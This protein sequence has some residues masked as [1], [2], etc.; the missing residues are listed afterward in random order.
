MSFVTKGCL[1]CLALIGALVLMIVLLLFVRFA[2]T[3]TGPT[4]QATGN[5]AAVT[6][7]IA[8]QNAYGQAETELQIQCQGSGTVRNETVTA[9]NAYYQ[10]YAGWTATVELS[11][12]C[13]GQR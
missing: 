7:A 8:L 9:S 6:R 12:Q 5:G 4:I 3:H 1:G 10:G 2:L 13:A 11:A